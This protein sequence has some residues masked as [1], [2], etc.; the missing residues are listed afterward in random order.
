MAHPLRPF[1]PCSQHNPRRW[2]ENSSRDRNTRADWPFVWIWGIESRSLRERKLGEHC[3]EYIAMVAAITTVGFSTSSAGSRK[4]HSRNITNAERWT[5]GRA[6]GSWLILRIGVDRERNGSDR[7]D[8]S[9]D[10]TKCIKTTLWMDVGCRSVVGSFLIV[11]RRR[12]KVSSSTWL[13]LCWRS[14]WKREN[15]FHSCA[16]RPLKK[17]VG[18]A[19]VLLCSFLIF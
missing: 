11:I 7:R 14:V 15:L 9:A 13:L 5:T 10:P 1:F 16:F 6:L 19:S 3:Y 8:R 18:L 17:S 12:R 2:G 4:T